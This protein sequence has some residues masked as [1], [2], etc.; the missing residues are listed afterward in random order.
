MNKLS[1]ILLCSLIYLQCASTTGAQLIHQV[2]IEASTAFQIKVQ[3]GE[4]SEELRAAS[5]ALSFALQQTLHLRSSPQNALQ[6]KLSAERAVRQPALPTAEEQGFRILVR[7]R[8]VEIIGETPL[9]TWFGV[10]TLLREDISLLFP[11]RDGGVLTRS[12]PYIIRARPQ[13]QKPVFAIRDIYSRDGLDPG[14]AQANRLMPSWFTNRL[15]EKLNVKTGYG[16]GY[17]AHTL[18]KFL[19]GSGEAGLSLCQPDNSKRLREAVIAHLGANPTVSWVDLSLPDGTRKVRGSVNC[20]GTTNDQLAAFI[21]AEKSSIQRAVGR[22]IQFSLLAYQATREQVP[23][24]SIPASVRLTTETLRWRDQCTP[25]RN[26]PET[27]AVIRKWEEKT[28]QLI[29]WDYIVDF[30]NYDRPLPNL[31]TLADDLRYYQELGVEGVFLQG[32]SQAGR[33]G[34]QELRY[35]VASQLLWNPKANLEKLVTTFIKG[36]YG[37]AASEI[38]IYHS[39]WTAKACRSGYPELGASDYEYGG[40]LLN[41][42]H[43]KSN[44]VFKDRITLLLISHLKYGLDHAKSINLYRDDQVEHL[45]RLR[46]LGMDYG[47]NEKG[48]QAQDFYLRKKAKLEAPPVDGRIAIG[49]DLLKLVRLKNR[50]NTHPK[51]VEEKTSPTGVS[52]VQPGGHTVW[53]VQFPVK[54]HLPANRYRIEVEARMDGCPTKAQWSCGSYRPAEKAYDLRVSLAPSRTFNRLLVGEV[55]VD[56]QTTLYFHPGKAP[57]CSQLHIARVIFSPI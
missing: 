34:W 9:G 54:E 47:T 27:A 44:G 29:I 13:V 30:S 10:Q 57:A 14:Y 15:P 16:R 20:A 23:S 28:N 31:H 3:P 25:I 42:A 40:E 17:G 4:L 6:F 43:E 32:D 37:E 50:E 33:G 41:A 52:I 48:E 5:G 51:L 55:T 19:P 12:F 24:Q 38:M 53:S 26:H 2:N 8:E 49:A 21:A 7:E 36:Y 18:E 35:W 11:D 22:D 46:S 39:L 56:Q 45:E 1:L